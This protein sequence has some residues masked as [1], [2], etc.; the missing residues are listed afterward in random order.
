MLRIV[1]LP[2][3]DDMLIYIS[4]HKT[5]KYDI[6]TLLSD[7]FPKH[8]ST[9]SLFDQATLLLKCKKLKSSD[10]VTFVVL[11]VHRNLA[12]GFCQLLKED[13]GKKHRIINLCRNK[14]KRYVGIGRSIIDNLLSFAYFQ[15]LKELYLSVEADNSR[16]QRYYIAIGWVNTYKY[17]I[18]SDIPEFEFKW[19]F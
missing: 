1:T 11:D 16:L 2:T 13:N 4:K 15:N 7:S 14:S 19:V 3:I 17:D 6:E 10:I 5:F 18:H 9:K 12:M 8:F